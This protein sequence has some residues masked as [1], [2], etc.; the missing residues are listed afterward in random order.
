VPAGKQQVLVGWCCCKAGGVRWGLPSKQS[1]LCASLLNESTRQTRAVQPAQHSLQD[2]LLLQGLLQVQ[3]NTVLTA[4]QHSTILALDHASTDVCAH[5]MVCAAQ[6]A[7]VGPSQPSQQLPSR[8]AC[9]MT[10][11]LTRCLG[12]GNW[13]LRVT[14]KTVKGRQLA[15]I[16]C[17][18]AS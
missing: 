4:V 18:G 15:R 2:S 7:L 11:C 1:C 5:A 9:S 16:L 10:S 6:L 13:Q 8:V 17:A 12:A 14:Q 3:Q